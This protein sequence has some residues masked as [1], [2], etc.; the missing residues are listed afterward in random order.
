MGCTL[1]EWLDRLNDEQPKTAERFHADLLQT[2]NATGADLKDDITAV[3]I[4]M[5]V[6]QLQAGAGIQLRGVA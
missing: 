2:V 1:D 6:P 3:I 5:Q 4:E